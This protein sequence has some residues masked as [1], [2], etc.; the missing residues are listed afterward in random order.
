MY[1]AL[2]NIAKKFFSEAQIFKYG[3]NISPMYR[4]STGKV[5]S[6]TDDLKEVKIKI[7]L[8]YKNKNYVGSIFGGSLFSATDPIYMIQLLNILGDNYVVWDKSS[9]IK[10][11][12]PA[13][14]NAYASFVFSDEEIE[15]IKQKVADKK[16]IDIVKTLHIVGENDTVFCEVSK[17]IYVA[18]KNYYR[19]KRKLKK[20]R[21]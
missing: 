9:E 7:P 3:F 19:E 17:V 15:V 1:K 2:S 16:E 10:F 21:K 11:K 14:T 20:Q 12:R 13:K 4:R 6:I 8:S 18:D 5:I